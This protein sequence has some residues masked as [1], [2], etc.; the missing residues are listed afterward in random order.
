MPAAE[1]N[2]EQPPLVPDYQDRSQRAPRGAS[3]VAVE[4][5]KKFTR[6]VDASVDFSA[7]IDYGLARWKRQDAG[8]PEPADSRSRYLGECFTKLEAYYNNSRKEGANTKTLKASLQDINSGKNF[9]KI[10]CQKMGNGRSQARSD[11][12]TELRKLVVSAHDGFKDC[13]ACGWA[14]DGCARLLKT[15][16]T[17]LDDAELRQQ[18]T[19]K[20]TEVPHREMYAGLYANQ[21][22]PI[23][24]I[25]AMV[26]FM[27]S[28][29]F[30]AAAQT[31][32]TGLGSAFGRPGSGTRSK[33]YSAEM[34][35]FNAP[36]LAY[37]AMM[38]RFV[39][40]APGDWYVV[41]KGRN[42][43]KDK[44]YDYDLFYVELVTFLTKPVFS[45]DLQELLKAVNSEVF[46]NAHEHPQQI[47]V[48]GGCSMAQLAEEAEIARAA[49]RAA[50]RREAAEQEEEHWGN[51]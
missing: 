28:D 41:P 19:L 34:T 5:G 24:A 18:L 36:A 21:E 20:Q 2:A 11:D 39:L 31:I 38:L 23:N 13:N 17:D 45:E 42:G 16:N 35:S 29:Q 15:R 26:G 25:D 48:P 10:V 43:R 44:R 40:C 1:N 47:T 9:R 12:A 50:A 6:G 30:I 46:P 7:L 49:Q 37:V 32:F 8:T 22:F 14:D 33:A 51:Q 4:T 3:A 27:R